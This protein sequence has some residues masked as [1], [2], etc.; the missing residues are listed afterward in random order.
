MPEVGVRGAGGEDQ[1]VVREIAVSEM[2][3]LRAEIDRLRLAEDDVR[4]F[5]PPKD[6]ADGVRDDGWIERRRGH[7]VEQRLEDVVVAAID[8]RDRHRRVA[9]RLRRVQAAEA[10]ADDD[11]TGTMSDGR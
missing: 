7:L 4:V 5:L 3:D 6:R 11:D 1:I 2:D 10:A 8:E 9:Q